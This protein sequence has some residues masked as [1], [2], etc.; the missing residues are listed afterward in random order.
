MVKH[1][2]LEIVEYIVESA[3]VDGYEGFSLFD[4][5]NSLL[6][7][8]RLPK[9]LSF[10][11][12]QIVKRS[13]VNFRRILKVNKSVN[14][15][16]LGL[17]LQVNSTLFRVNN[18]KD[19]LT[20]LDKIHGLLL[21]LKSNSSGISWGYN[22]YWPK[23]KDVDVPAYTPNV[24]VTCFIGRGAYLAYKATG[25]KKWKDLLI[26]IGYFLMS[27]IHIYRGNDGACFSYTI[28][29]KDKVIN[30]NM[31]TAEILTYIDHISDETNYKDTVTEIIKFTES[32]QNNDGSWWYS[33][34]YSNGAPK[35]QLDF[36]QGYVLE[37]LKRVGRIR[38]DLEARIESMIKR[39]DK[40]YLETILDT[41]VGR[42]FWRY[43]KKFP[44][45]IHNQAQAIIWL[46]LSGRTSLAERF[47]KY[48]LKNFWSKR[49]RYFFYQKYPFFTNRTNYM[50]WS[51]GWM[52]VALTS[53][54][55]KDEIFI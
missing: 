30:V 26:D 46:S 29:Q 27:D 4:S 37:S 15:K 14:P 10:Y 25:D 9:T 32:C 11:I 8:E 7:L 24:V 50:R 48:T 41:E 6:P 16:M 5:H 22:Y 36:H 13:P 23:R 18:S 17:M 12:N 42:A 40:F 33:H 54:Y 20:R 45:D 55:F 2:N 21:D 19:C 1:K 34:H 53:I 51:N 43:P 28:A 31:L 47:V 38:V 39:G 44:I 35:K 49:N 52:S 3:D